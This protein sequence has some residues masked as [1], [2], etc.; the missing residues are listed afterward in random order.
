MVEFHAFKMADNNYDV[1]I[2]GAGISGLKAAHTIKKRDPKL[3]VKVLE[4]KDRVGGRTQTVSMLSSNGTDL[5]DLGGQWVGRSQTHIIK[6]LKELELTTY[7]QFIEG[8]KC[9]Q[10][11]E[12]RIRTYKSNIPKLSLFS[13]LDLH[14]NI[15]KVDKLARQLSTVDPFSHPQA[16][17]WDSMTLDTFMNKNVYTRATREAIEAAVRTMFGCEVNQ[18]S[19]LYYIFFI[20]TAGGIENLIEATENRAQEWKISGGAQQISE[21]LADFIGKENVQLGDAV[22]RIQQTDDKVTVETASGWRGQ[23]SYI[24]LAMP[25]MAIEHIQ[26][27]PGLS[28]D[29]VDF[30][31]RMPM[32]N[33][34]KVI[35]TYKQAFWRI[36]KLSGEIVSNGGE[37][38]V[39]GC[40]RGPISVSYDA[41]SH[42]GSP[43]LVAFIAG[44]PAIEWANQ[45]AEVRQKA[46]LD[47]FASFFGP[48]AHKFVDYREKDWNQES[49]SW[50]APVS[51]VSPGGMKHFSKSIR[52][53]QGR[54]HFAGTET[55]TSFTGYMNGAVQAGERAA[56]EI[57]FRLQPGSLFTEDHIVLKETSLCE[58]GDGDSSRKNSSKRCLK[59]NSKSHM[60][61]VVKLGVG[62]GILIGSAYLVAWFVKRG[63]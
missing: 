58:L 41:T 28:A 37:T 38:Q 23:A 49:F 7:P 17:E 42:S 57:L 20:S 46:V 54:I 55:A 26:I 29:W 12:S 24:I 47:H 2:V 15:S 9:Q 51:Y 8:T 18:L 44:E 52:C 30:T 62:V 25:P 19:F 16:T 35:V 39:K 43:A 53:P 3:S 4:G 48:E 5:W 36:K 32:G 34:I 22:T 63:K 61:V 50:G 40:V 21:K 56:L 27:T 33:M 11:G 1:I 13:L 31:K 6:L 14:F 60:C 45:S 10:L 59:T